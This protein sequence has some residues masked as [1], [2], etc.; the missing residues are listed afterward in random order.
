MMEPPKIWRERRGK[1]LALGIECLDCKTKQFPVVDNCSTCN[2]N[3]L[4]EYKLAENGKILYFTTVTK[5][6]DEM[7]VN[8]PYIIALIELSDGIKITGQIVDCNYEEL[9]EG[10]DVRM[11][12]RILAKDGSE[13]LIRYGYKF[14][15][16]R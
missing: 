2:S 13:G 12:F 7:M 14:S 10:M 8:A 16:C 15:P 4:K 11:I 3:N 6:I 1:Y 9:E 5:T